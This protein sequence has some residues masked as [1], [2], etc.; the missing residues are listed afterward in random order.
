MVHAPKQSAHHDARMGLVEIR[1]VEVLEPLLAGGVPD[2]CVAHHPSQRSPQPPYTM[3]TPGFRDPHHIT[4]CHDGG[5][6]A[7]VVQSRRTRRTYGD[8]I[9]GLVYEVVSEQGERERGQ[10]V[11]LVSIH[12]KALH[13][14][15]CRVARMWCEER[16]IHTICSSRIRSYPGHAGNR[17]ATACPR[18]CQDALSFA[19]R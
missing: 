12:Q 17:S 8:G 4:T 18:T 19:H 2:V 13:Q 7:C 6:G 1:R 10:L 11:R 15:G 14:P 3:R 9:T 5:G 16:S